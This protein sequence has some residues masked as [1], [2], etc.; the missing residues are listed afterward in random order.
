[1]AFTNTSFF[2]TSGK[3]YGAIWISSHVMMANHICG[4]ELQC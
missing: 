2:V 4:L 1:M 3:Y